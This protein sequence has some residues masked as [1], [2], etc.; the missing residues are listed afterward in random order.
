MDLA[1][2]FDRIRALRRD[3][4]DPDAIVG[5]LARIRREIDQAQADRD[6]DPREPEHYSMYAVVRAALDLEEGRLTGASVPDGIAASMIVDDFE[7]SRQT[8][9]ER[10]TAANEARAASRA[11]Y[12]AAFDTNT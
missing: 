10:E 5:E 9:E 3:A 6:P 2:A 8:R 4:R 11:K 1:A 7:T 12:A